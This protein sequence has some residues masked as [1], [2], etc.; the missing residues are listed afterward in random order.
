MAD[1]GKRAKTKTR[2]GLD[3]GQYSVKIVELAGPADKPELISFGMRRLGAP[4]KEPTPQAIRSLVSE[5]NISAKDVSISV[6]G[7]SLVVRLISMPKM[8][9]DELA[10]AIR[11]ETEK[12]IPFDIEECVLDYQ[13]LAGHAADKSYTNILL[14]AAKR[15]HVLQKIKTAEEAGFSVKT[16][17]ADIFAAINSFLRNMPSTED[18]KT[19]ALVNIGSQ[20]TALGILRGGIPVF[21]RE[22]TMGS[23]DFVSAIAKKSAID[24]DKAAELLISPGDK[25][26]EVIGMTKGAVGA[27]LDEIK[28]SFG[29]HENQSGRG[30]DEVYI[31]GGGTGIVGLDDA[32]QDLFGLKVL[33]WNPLNFVSNASPGSPEAEKMNSAYCVAVGLALRGA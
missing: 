29:Y 11:F 32:F 3:I 31:S 16:V 23:G 17:D 15:E 12:F 10:S 14:A 4:S 25:S 18:Q 9:D 19:M 7:P 8:N 22:I 13:I 27:L 30:I 21:V 2:A 1:P 20:T 24:L 28:L 5:L 26:A 33:R 6:S